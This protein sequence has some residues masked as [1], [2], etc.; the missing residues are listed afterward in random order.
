MLTIEDFRCSRRFLFLVLALAFFFRHGS[1]AFCAVTNVLSSHP[2]EC[3][4]P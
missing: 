4:Q 3:K 2:F 1:I